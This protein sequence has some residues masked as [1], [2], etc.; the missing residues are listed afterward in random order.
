[1]HLARLYLAIIILQVYCHHMISPPLHRELWQTGSILE[2]P[3][4]VHLTTLLLST[5]ATRMLD[6]GSVVIMEVGENSA[7]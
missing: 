6:T 2:H 5:N 3:H 4:K 7:E 1:M